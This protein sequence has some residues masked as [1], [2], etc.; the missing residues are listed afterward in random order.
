MSGGQTE[1]HSRLGWASGSWSQVPEA[2]WGLEQCSEDR[3]PVW[4]TRW[5]GRRRGGSPSRPSLGKLVFQNRWAYNGDPSH[6]P[7]ASFQFTW[8]SIV[9]ADSG[10]LYNKTSDTRRPRYAASTSCPRFKGKIRAPFEGKLRCGRAILGEG[11][12][13]VTW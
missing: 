3:A 6:S 1:M 13:A 4:G 5:E 11:G 9:D 12:R 7:G 10:A 8:N 2:L